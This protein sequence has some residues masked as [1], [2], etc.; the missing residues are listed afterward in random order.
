MH[1]G[2]PLLVFYATLTKRQQQVLQLVVH[3]Y[4]N[5]EIA[6]T[7]YIE[8]SVVAGHLTNIYELLH[9]HLGT[10]PHTRPNRY[11]VIRLFAVFFDQHPE[12]DYSET[13]IVSDR[14]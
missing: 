2:N 9:I 10:D 7:L 14:N 6:Q 8:P 5:R 4:S 3:G 13:V 1:N 12:L 11:T